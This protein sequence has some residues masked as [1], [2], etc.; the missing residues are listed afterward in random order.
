MKIG[1]VYLL[2][3]QRNGTVYIGVTSDIVGRVWEHKHKIHEGFSKKYNVIK[4]VWYKEFDD[5]TD[6]IYQEKQMKK[7]KRAW[8]IE[9]IEKI[10]PLWK[11]L[12]NDLI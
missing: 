9:L 6:A 12:Y 2:A 7:W 11:D 1:Y 8:K 4:L 3:S 10:N 5:I